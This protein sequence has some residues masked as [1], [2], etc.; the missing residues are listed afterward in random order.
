MN[1]FISHSRANKFDVHLFSDEAKC[2]LQIPASGG[3]LRLETI[4]VE[5]FCHGRRLISTT[6]CRPFVVLGISSLQADYCPTNWRVGLSIDQKCLVGSV[7]VANIAK[8][9][10]VGI[11]WTAG[12]LGQILLPNS[13]VRFNQKTTKPTETDSRSLLS[14]PSWWISVLR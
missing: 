8:L 6:G 1:T 10:P 4:V 7:A 14:C 11:H 9:S 13:Y 12:G 5:L 2:H 3:S